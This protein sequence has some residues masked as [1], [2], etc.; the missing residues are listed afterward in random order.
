MELRIFS[1]TGSDFWE[2][3]GSFSGALENFEIFGNLRSDLSPNLPR[4][5]SPPTPVYCIKY[6]IM[7][8]DIPNKFR[9][10]LS[11][12]EN[13]NDH[14]W[15][16]IQRSLRRFLPRS[17]PAAAITYN[18]L[19]PP[20]PCRGVP[21]CHEDRLSST[22]RGWEV[23]RVSSDRTHDSLSVS[24]FFAHRTREWHMIADRSATEKGALRHAT[25]WRWLVPRFVPS[26]ASF[27]L[28]I[29][30]KQKLFPRD[31]PTVAEGLAILE[32]LN[33]AE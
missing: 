20:P 10:I 26:I 4:V 11:V 5:S 9:G 2:R 23:G 1:G 31:R 32:N 25:D 29:A 21:A 27:R 7:T 19:V 15:Q 33:H 24:Q 3:L 30:K 18:A 17:L 22:P 14:R 6:A 16:T 13:P 8:F 28:V 12:N